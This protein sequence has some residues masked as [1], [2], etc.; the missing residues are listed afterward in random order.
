MG[1]TCWMP[2]RW[3][4][5]SMN[6]PVP[7]DEASRKLSGETHMALPADWTTWFTVTSAAASFCGSTATCSWRSCWPHITTLATPGTLISRGRMV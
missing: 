3:L 6:P 2:S 4:D 1:E 5:V 7:G